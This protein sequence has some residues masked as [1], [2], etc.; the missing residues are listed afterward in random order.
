MLI[1]HNNTI[2]FK[3]THKNIPQLQT[4]NLVETLFLAREYGV[5]VWDDNIDNRINTEIHPVTKTILSTT[6][7]NYHWV[8]SSLHGI[9][10]LGDLINYGGPALVII[11]GG[12]ELALIK[13]WVEFALQSNIDV[14][15]LSVMFRLPNEQAEFNQYV[16][17]IGLNN[18]VSEN[19]KLVFVSTK[20]T[21]PLIKS[22]IKFNTVINLGYYSYMHFSMSTVVDNARNLVYYSMKQPTKQNKWLP[23]EL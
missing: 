19:T 16:K 3:N 9:E 18:P 7:N 22:G 8:N 4:S 20:I 21:K 14:S 12:S 23:R 17:E 10:T 13:S 15:K 2:E 5:T 1:Q 11:P 6:S